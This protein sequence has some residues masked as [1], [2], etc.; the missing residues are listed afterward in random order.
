MT[1]LALLDLSAAFDTVDHHIL[2][3]RLYYTYGIGGT[4]PEWLH[5][6]LTGRTQVVNFAG[7]HS[8]TS[9]LTCGVPQGST[10][11]PLLFS[12]Y[13]A[14]VVRIAQSFGVSVHCYADDLKLYVHCRADE[15]ATAITQLLAYIQAID[16]WMGSNRLKMNPDK[17]HFI[18]L[19]SRQQLSAVDVTPLHLHDGTVIMPSTTVRNLG[20]V[21]DC[22]MTMLYHVNS[23]T[24][25]CF[26]HLRQLRT[27]RR[28]L[29]HDS[30]KMLAQCLRLEQSRLLQFTSLRSLST[31]TTQNAGCVECSCSTCLRSRTV[32]PHHA[33]NEK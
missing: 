28:A 15:A 32:R 22:E 4:V 31:C 26:Y 20:A 16:R 17:T 7:E 8:S 18:W 3:Q 21:F 10:V 2:L 6:F 33:S 25:S 14:D 19:G 23:V 12:L 27:V 1:L 30:A 13:T 24:R 29:T 11:S 9:T 5:S